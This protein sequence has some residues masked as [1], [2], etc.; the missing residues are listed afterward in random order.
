M[1]LSDRFDTK[2]SFIDMLLSGQM[3]LF[4]LF[5][6]ALALVNPKASKD[7]IPPKAEYILAME[8]ASGVDC[9]VDLWVRG[10]GGGVV[11]F[12]NKDTQGMHIERDDTGMLNDTY[13]V[14]ANGKTVMTTENIE[15]WVLR[16]V[17]PGTYTVNAH[18]YAC[19]P[20]LQLAVGTNAIQVNFTLTKVNPLLSVVAQD[21][22]VFDHVPQ[23][24]HAFR[25]EI[26]HLGMVSRV[27]EEPASLVKMELP[28]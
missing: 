19:R 7:G 23:E 8:W 2:T 26:N 3:N 13:I 17:T 11:W 22:V 27:W 25:F 16:A 12:R 28:R 24:K 14:G 10:P 5:L 20:S 15:H 9:D 4:I 21:M 1:N 6:M 18:L